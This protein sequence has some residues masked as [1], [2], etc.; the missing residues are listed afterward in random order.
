LYD[1][2][3]TGIFYGGVRMDGSSINKSSFDLKWYPRGVGG[4]ILF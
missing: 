2:L 4:D 1:K 3:F